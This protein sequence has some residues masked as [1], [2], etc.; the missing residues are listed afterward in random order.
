M[1]QMSLQ[2]TH[3]KVSMVLTRSH[4]Y[5]IHNYIITSKYYF[6]TYFIDRTGLEPAS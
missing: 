1:V 2:I 4:N 3:V 5:F 6:K